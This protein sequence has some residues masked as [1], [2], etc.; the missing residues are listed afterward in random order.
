MK[1]IVLAAG[2]AT[3]LYPLTLERAKPLLEVGGRPVLSRSLDRL[4]SIEDLSDVIVV[5]NAKFHAQ[6][7]EWRVTEDRPWPVRL[8][9]DGSLQ[10]EARLGAVRDLA[11]A[12]RITGSADV[13]VLAGD[14]LVDFDLAPYARAFQAL[15]R[16]LILVRSMLEVPPLRHGEVQI[17]NAGRVIVFREKP[18]DPRSR[19]V[20]TCLYFFPAA[21]RGWIAEYLVEGGETDAPG[22]FLEWL[23]TRHEVNAM[24]IQ[25]RLHDIGD[26]ASLEAARR[27]F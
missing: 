13:L 11:L 26:P 25:G 21:V 18:A 27:E 6:F 3:R 19:V 20:A 16:P 5:T 4:A 2:F 22:F 14:N 23:V 24:P 1:A 12:L 7:D 15:Q 9:N 10:N 8:L 17:D